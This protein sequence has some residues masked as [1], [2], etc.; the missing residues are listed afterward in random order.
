[1]EYDDNEY[2]N[3]K[4]MKTQFKRTTKNYILLENNDLFYIRKFKNKNIFNGEDKSLTLFLLVPTIDKLNE[5]LYQFHVNNFHANYKVIQELF[6]KERIGFY[7]INE[8]IEEYVSNC[9]VC[10]QSSRTLHR[11]D[12]IKS[13]NILG[14][15]IRYEF[16]ISYFNTD[17]AKAFGVKMILSIIDAFSRKAMIYPE[18]DKKA[19]NLVKDIIQFCTYNGF[20]KEFCSDNGPEFKN[21]KI[22]EICEREGIIFIHGVPYNP[23]SQG[24]VE[25]FHYTIKKYLGKEYINNSCKKLDFDSVRAR[26]MN[27]YNNKKHLLIGMTPNE[28]DN[29]R[30]EETIKK[31]NEIKNRE[32][33]KISKKRSYLENNDT[34]L[35]NLKFL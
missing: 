22:K 7:G 25:R 14:P 29:I 2:I 32:F 8:L 15:K 21:V 26:I 20:P 3:I 11:I 18:N 12:P 31:I 4:N 23:H 27:F 35:L 30:D 9:P 1:M 24:T 17:L 19:E 33:E 6:L 13:I 5:K 10:C 34:C 16:D 28:A